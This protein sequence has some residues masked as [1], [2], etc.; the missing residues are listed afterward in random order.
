MTSTP[1]RPEHITEREAEIVLDYLHTIATLV[2]LPRFEFDLDLTPCDDGRYASIFMHNQK[3]YAR[4]S[5]NAEWMEYPPDIK[6]NSMIH[7]V[8]HLL[9]HRLDHLIDDQIRYM[10]D[11]EH[12]A[13]EKAYVR[14]TELIIDQLARTLQDHAAPDWPDS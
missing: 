12:R 14:E 8:C 10:H 2:G 9:H 6:A 4:V 11:H 5:L 7:E 1:P 13:F 3:Y